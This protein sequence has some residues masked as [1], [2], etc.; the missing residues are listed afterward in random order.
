M[1]KILIIGAGGLGREAWN[2]LAQHPECGRS[3]QIAGFL[4]DNAGALEKF[5]YP[6]KVQGSI[7]EYLPKDD[8]LLVC[9]LGSPEI[10]QQVCNKLLARGAAFKTFV[11]HTALVGRN[12]IL[13]R[14]CFLAAH[15]VITGDARL[16]DFVTLNCHSTCGH[17]VTVGDFTTLSSYC[18]LTGG[19]ELGEK[20]FLG[21][22]ASIVPKRKI[23]DGAFIGAGSVVVTHLK[24]GKK[25]FG[26]PAKPLM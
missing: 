23:G 17:D 1:K 14:G 2:Y 13:G 20:V 6:V 26:V 25:V 21:S 18:D 11:H 12:V 3:W 15:V 9:A 10:K 22:H 7:S 8:E 16:G 5:D 19:V 4:D 24:P